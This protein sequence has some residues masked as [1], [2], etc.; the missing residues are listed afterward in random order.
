ME[1]IPLGTDGRGT[2]VLLRDVATIQEGP[3][4]RRGIADLD[5]EG[6]TVGG[7]VVMR[8]EENALDVIERVKEKLAEI[9][10]ALPEGIEVLPVYDRSALIERSIDNHTLHRPVSHRQHLPLLCE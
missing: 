9:E 10:P 5:G 4:L 2:P 3:D 6:E 7:I 1:M 8:Y